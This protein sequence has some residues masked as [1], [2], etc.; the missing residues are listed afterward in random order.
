[1][2]AALRR[3]VLIFEPGVDGHP[4]EWLQHLIRYAAGSR[5]VQVVL[6]IA[7]AL[8]RDLAA[9]LQLSAAENIRLVALRRREQSLCTHG[10]LPVSAFFRWWVMRRYMASTGAD[11]GHFLGID[12]LALPLALGLGIGGK[13]I[14]GI[15]FRPSCHYADL[16]PY[17]PTWRERLRDW[18]KDILYRLLLRNRCV[19]RVLTL[20]PYFPAFAERRYRNGDKVRWLPDPAHPAVNPQAVDRELVDRIP[21]HRTVL[22]LFGHLTERKGVLTLLDALRDLEPHVAAAIAIVLAGR[23]DGAILARV[24]Q[25]LATLARERPQLWIRLEDRRLSNGELHALVQ[26]SDMVLAPYWRFVGSS[27]VLLWAARAGKPV[28][29]QDYGLIAKLVRDNQLGVV[30]DTCDPRSIRTSIE[31]AALGDV[32]HLVDGR[33]LAHFLSAMT[34]QRFASEIVSSLLYA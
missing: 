4:K 3:A 15:L 28:L 20:D 11:A 26:R 13:P 30:A 16:G 23:V 25:K 31:R 18:R 2:T 10:M 27:G 32:R 6:V 14:S 7:E 5:D 29:T 9:D 33:K 19:R 1:M 24:T 17:R 21:A 12:H 34:P 22:V 8:R